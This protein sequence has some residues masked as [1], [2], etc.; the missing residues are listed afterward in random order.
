MRFLGPVL[1]LYFA[2]ASAA[3]HADPVATG[4]V[5]PLTARDASGVHFG[6]ALRWTTERLGRHVG[7]GVGWTLPQRWYDVDGQLLTE[8]SLLTP[9]GDLER[10]GFYLAL[11]F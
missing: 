11:R 2:L 6:T 9:G 8:R 7:L 4:A 1:V 10:S 3:A 5:P